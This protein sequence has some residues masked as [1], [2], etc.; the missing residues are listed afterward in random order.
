MPP[1]NAIYVKLSKFLNKKVLINLFD[2]AA[3]S[4]AHNADEMENVTIY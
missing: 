2:E 4:M 3:F 1:K